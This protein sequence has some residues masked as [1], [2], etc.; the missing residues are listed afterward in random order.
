MAALCAARWSGN[1]RQLENVLERVVVLLEGS[2]IR[3]QDLPP[4][5]ASG[6]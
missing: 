5:A 1:V 6:S 2:R 4:E 3:V